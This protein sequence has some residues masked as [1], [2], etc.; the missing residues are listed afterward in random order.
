VNLKEVH[1]WAATSGD[2]DP[3]K[4]EEL[5]LALVQ[6]AVRREDIV[7]QIIKHAYEHGLP[8]EFSSLAIPSA[9]SHDELETI[10]NQMIYS[11]FG[12]DIARVA[13]KQSLRGKDD[14][15]YPILI[16]FIFVPKDGTSS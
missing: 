12:P 13:S 9:N 2:F 5:S 6:E 16:W 3:G 14:K 15:R 11:S 10:S 4:L 8:I 7:A 1:V